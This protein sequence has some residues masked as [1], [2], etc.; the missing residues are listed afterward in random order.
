MLSDEHQRFEWCAL[1]AA[2]EHTATYG[3]MQAML[4]LVDTHL[5]LQHQ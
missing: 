2:L 1:P 5:E 4:A 3:D